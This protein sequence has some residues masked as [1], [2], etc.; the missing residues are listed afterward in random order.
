MVSVLLPTTGR[1]EMAEKCVRR[2][3]ETTTQ[4]LELCI[5]VDRD[6]ETVKHLKHIHYPDRVKKRLDLSNAYR[7][8]SRAWNDA[9]ALSHGDPV[10]FA[11]DDLEWGEGWLDAALEALRKHP[12]CLIG[13]NDGHWGEELS[14]HYVAPRNFIIEVLGG[15]LSWD[16]AHSFN[17][18]E[19]T[20]RARRA[21]RYYWCEE[22]RVYHSHWIFGDRVKDETDTRTLGSHGE[23]E[24][25]FKERR[26]A[27]F[28]NDMRPIITR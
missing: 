13:L 17:D 28:P 12:G 24:A 4:P 6:L 26:A 2:L 16:Y 19:T 7:G 5:A 3:I 10:V 1:A 11:A 23:S 27:G 20:E 14:T 18:A 21:N 8:C 15:R 9:L 25:R 22:A